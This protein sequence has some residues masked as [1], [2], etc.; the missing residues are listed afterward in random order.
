MSGVE[1]YQKHLDRVSRSFAYCISKLDTPLRGWVSLTYLICRILDTVEDAPWRKLSQQ[2]RQF[3]EFDGFL[4]APPVDERMA[5]WQQAF[6]S[7]IPEGE[8]LL[9]MD[10]TLIFKDLHAVPLTVRG[11]IQEMVECMSA[12]MQYYS[13]LRRQ[14][15]QLRLRNLREVNQYCFFVAGVVGETLARLVTVVEPQLKVA[16]RLVVQAHHFGLF[17]QKINLLKDQLDDER[18]GRFFVHSRPEIRRSLAKNALGA[19]QFLANIP[20]SQRGFRLFCG[21]SLFLGLASLPW[22]EKAYVRKLADKIPRAAT[23]ELF[24]L[25]ERNIDDNQ[26][27]ESLFYDLAEAGSLEIHGVAESV[28]Q[29]FVGPS[30]RD[31]DWFNRLYRGELQAADFVDLGM[32]GA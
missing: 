10:S 29:D 24:G 23:M 27:L 22:I 16:Q 28:T 3:G 17:L 2:L 6:P 12:G 30:Q 14:R 1:F 19:W 11:V 32:S 9:L 18:E 15:G 20:V 5:D 8:R 26:Y 31:E 4:T 25:I 7:E 21:H 13:R